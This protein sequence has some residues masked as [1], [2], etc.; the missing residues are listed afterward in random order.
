[1]KT[2]LGPPGLPGSFAEMLISGVVDRVCASLAPRMGILEKQVLHL[3]DLL[4]QRVE[5]DVNVGHRID[6]LEAI[7]VCSPSVDDVLS[8]MLAVAK[9]PPSKL[10]SKQAPSTPTSV[11]T[12]TYFDLT[13]GDWEELQ[14]APDTVNKFCEG[15]PLDTTDP[16]YVSTGDWRCIPLTAWASIHERFPSSKVGVFAENAEEK[17]CG[18]T[19]EEFKLL[20]RQFS[21]ELLTDFR[22]NMFEGT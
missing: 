13:Q 14:D 7:T 6:R 3:S 12:C 19:L 16:E 1:M 2:L 22:Q 5:T 9:N 8:Q 11:S 15:V 10:I 4:A 21:D 20:C 18:V 17:R